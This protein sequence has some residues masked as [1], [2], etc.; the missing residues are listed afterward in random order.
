VAE[1]VDKDPGREHGPGREPLRFV[2]IARDGAVLDDFSE[3]ELTT[4]RLF[5]GKTMQEAVI[6]FLIGSA[7]GIVFGVLLGRSRFLAEPV[8]VADHNCNDAGGDDHR[9]S[10]LHEP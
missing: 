8:D 5:P 4:A 2:V 1:R 7:L 10:R 3:D 9:Y 6:G